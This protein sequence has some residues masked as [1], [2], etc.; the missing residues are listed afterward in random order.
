M[1]DVPTLLEAITYL[2]PVSIDSYSPYRE[3]AFLD[4]YTCLPYERNQLP[5]SSWRN[6][7]GEYDSCFAF[8][9]YEVDAA[10]YKYENA[11]ETAQDWPQNEHRDTGVGHHDNAENQLS[12]D[13]GIWPAYESWFG[14]L[15]EDDSYYYAYNCSPDEGELFQSLSVGIKA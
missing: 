7:D 5:Y 13:D 1:S 14:Y 10:T 6:W 4:D 11:L 12:Y 8:T 9:G 2:H 3:D 15:G